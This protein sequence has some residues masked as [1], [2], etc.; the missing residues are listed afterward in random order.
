[1]GVDHR[2]AHITMAQQLLNGA[3]VVVRHQQVTGKAVP[4]ML[5]SA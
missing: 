2:G 1:M 3:D 5:N 4:I